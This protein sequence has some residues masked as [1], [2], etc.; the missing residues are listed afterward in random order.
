MTQ[1][2]LPML[3]GFPIEGA[4]SS[5][6]VKIAI[7]GPPKIGKTSSIGRAYAQY[8]PAT[9]IIER[10]RIFYVAVS[11]RTA[12][13]ALKFQT[14]PDGKTVTLPDTAIQ[15]AYLDPN[16]LPSQYNNIID[17]FWGI[18]NGLTAWY[19]AWTPEQRWW[20]AV[21]IDGLN[22]LG[23]AVEQHFEKRGPRGWAKWDKLNEFFLDQLI[24]WATNLGRS[25]GHG[26][27]VFFLGHTTDPTY[28]S[29]GPNSGQLKTRGA[30]ALPTRRLGEQ[31]AGKVDLA[32]RADSVRKPGALE[33]ERTLFSRP[34]PNW[35]LGSRFDFLIN[36]QEQ[37]D[38]TEVLRRL[39]G[40]LGRPTFNHAT[41]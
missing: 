25:R 6:N 9:G 40:Y 19:D 29:E 17:A 3:G 14:L 24:A 16:F 8:N 10:Y 41:R 39:R 7:G 12:L 21:A 13:T 22:F 1:P 15:Q 36:P 18:A 11:D 32:L 2:Q 26:L 30:M 33:P 20:D 5:E 34:D 31:F 4:L 28:H 23:Q 35:M 27:E 37:L 38:L